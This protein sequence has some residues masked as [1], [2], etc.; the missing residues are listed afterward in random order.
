MEKKQGRDMR[1]AVPEGPVTQAEYEALANFRRTLR[2]F[3]HFSELAA[4]EAGV[5]PQQHQ[6]LLALRAAPDSELVTV[7]DLADTLQTCH[8]SAV[9]LVDRLASQG[10][11]ERRHGAADRRTVYVCL[12]PKG[13]DVLEALTAAHRAELRRLGPRLSHLMHHLQ[14]DPR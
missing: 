1:K 6:A 5:T 11:V 10:L 4:R 9:G 7:G 13:C 12:T 8:H 3:L 14:T 2:Q